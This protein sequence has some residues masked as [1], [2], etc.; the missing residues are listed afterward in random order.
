MP[1]EMRKNFVALTAEQI[2]NIKNTPFTSENFEKFKGP[3]FCFQN[4]ALK[5][6][7]ITTDLMI[8]KDV[9]IENLE[10]QLQDSLKKYQEL[11]S[12]ARAYQESKAKRENE[13]KEKIK[14]L[15]SK[16]RELKDFAKTLAKDDLKNSGVNKFY[17]AGDK[18]S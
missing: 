11:L 7:I 4:F 2:S 13:Q 1:Q 6:L 12:D 8:R 9:Q 5:V 15:T 18:N 3:S 10:S 17:V 14:M 16:L